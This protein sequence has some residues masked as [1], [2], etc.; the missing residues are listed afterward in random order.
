[1]HSSRMRTARFIGR[2]GG[3]CLPLRLG[4]GV[5]FS[6]WGVY[7]TPFTTPFT[8][9][10]LPVDRQ[11]PVKTAPCHKLRLRAVKMGSIVLFTKSVTLTVRCKRALRVSQSYKSLVEPL[12]N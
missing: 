7:Y 8:T 6:V 12:H 10:P 2:L 11:K 4:G 9:T 1:M 5:R 3:G